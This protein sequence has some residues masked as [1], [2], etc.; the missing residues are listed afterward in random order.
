MTTVH[1]IAASAKRRLIQRLRRLL[2]QRPETHF[3]CVHGSSL[4]PGG[5]FRDID[6]AVWVEASSAPPE[7]ALEY[8]WALSSYL[9]RQVEYPID[10]RVLNWSS[11]GFRYAAS[12]GILLFAKDKVLWYN[13][14]EETWNQ[15]LDF[16]PLPTQ[17]FF[18][19][20]GAS[21]HPLA[22]E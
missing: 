2:P 11:L 21:T 15:Y 19:L 13:F 20:L 10:L 8:G 12:G 1:Y 4:L 3:A 9:E 18:D 16:A 17:M 14:R 5:G 22:P 6:I 7:A